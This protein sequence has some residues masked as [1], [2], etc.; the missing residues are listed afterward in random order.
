MTKRFKQYINQPKRVDL[1]ALQVCRLLETFCGTN[2]KWS[3]LTERMPSETVF[4]DWI[5]ANFNVVAPTLAPFLT[6]DH[7]KERETFGLWALELL[8]N[9]PEILERLVYID[10]TIFSQKCANSYRPDQMRIVVDRGRQAPLR[11]YCHKPRSKAYE[12]YQGIMLGAKTTPML[13]RDAGSK[14]D[15]RPT[16]AD[17]KFFLRKHVGPMVEQ[18]RKDLGLDPAETFYIV[19]DHAAVHRSKEVREY[20]KKKWGLEVFGL[21]SRCPELNVIEVLWFMHKTA[22]RSL[23]FE[24]T[25]A[26]FLSAVRD[27]CGQATQEK[28]DN[29]IRSFPARCRAIIRSKGAAFKFRG[30]DYEFEYLD[31]VEESE[32]EESDQED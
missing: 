7:E 5:H 8:T 18:R 29:L 17:V 15:V 1:G 32:D 19:W 16:V 2:G 26:S 10:G 11:S 25:E 31:D 4:R 14:R 23:T 24:D 6:S 30:E 20:M 12:L 9:H 3:G 22:L 27:A 21:P 28:I 13:L